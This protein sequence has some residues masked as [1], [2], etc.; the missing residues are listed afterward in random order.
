MEDRP[1]VLFRCGDGL[2]F[3]LLLKRLKSGGR[4]ESRQTGPD[5]DVLNPQVQQGQENTDCFLLIPGENQGEREAID[6]GM[7]YFRQRLGDLYRRI[8]VV[9]LTDIQ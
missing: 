5:T 8:R 6:I 7:K 1:E 3:K 4:D 2:Q 9:A